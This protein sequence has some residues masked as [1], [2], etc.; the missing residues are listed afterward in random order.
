MTRAR[1]DEAEPR[2]LAGLGEI[3]VLGQKA[4]AG[5][6]RVGAVGRRRAD[7][8]GDV[9]VAVLGCGR[10]DTDRFVGHPHVQRVLVGGRIDRDR[11]DS[12]FAAGTDDPDCDRAAIRDQ[13]FLEH[14]ESLA[15][16]YTTSNY[17]E[18]LAVFDRV[19]VLAQ[20]PDHAAAAAGDSISFI[21]F[22]ASIMH[23]GWPLRTEPPSS[24]NGAAS[25]E[26]AR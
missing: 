21:I 4:V 20:D 19:A 5:M 13:Q 24:T 15:P 11:R 3:A 14:R 2:A 9:E 22:I 25:G 16:L 26:A 1:T 18:R 23:S 6:D 17:H 7:N 8:R 10:A 12:Q